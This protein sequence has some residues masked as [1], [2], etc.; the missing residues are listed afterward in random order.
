M[1]FATPQG[2]PSTPAVKASRVE[3]GVRGDCRLR[4]PAGQRSSRSAVASTDPF[5]GLRLA[6]LPSN[7][8]W[9]LGGKARASSGR[10]RLQGGEGLRQ[11]A[12]FAGHRPRVGLGGGGGDGF[13]SPHPSPPLLSLSLPEAAGKAAAAARWLRRPSAASVCCRRR[14][15]C[16]RRRPALPCRGACWTD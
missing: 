7:S 4:A 2:Q 6:S 9:G 11:A 1:C 14:C 16:P 15:R 5:A 10:L 8:S 12:L 13:G 3:G